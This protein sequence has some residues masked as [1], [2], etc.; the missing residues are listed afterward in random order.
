MEVHKK[1]S[2]CLEH[3]NKDNVKEPRLFSCPSKARVRVHRD[4]LKEQR[5][6]VKRCSVMKHVDVESKLILEDVE[7]KLILDN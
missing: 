4:R 1:I 5:T 6:E 2:L 3:S 7:S